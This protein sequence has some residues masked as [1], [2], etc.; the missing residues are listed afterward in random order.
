MDI[1][2]PQKLF[3]LLTL[4]NAMQNHIYHNK[5]KP[6]VLQNYSFW[7]FIMDSL[8]LYS[9]LIAGGFFTCKP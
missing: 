2:N 9:L 5:P 4:F 8:I 3:V 7:W 6:N 1:G